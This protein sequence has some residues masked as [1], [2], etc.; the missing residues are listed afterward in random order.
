MSN[1]S[2]VDLQWGRDVYFQVRCNFSFSQQ[3]KKI[4]LKITFYDFQWDV[5][6]N[7]DF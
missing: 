3:F 1:R 6:G 4:L 2:Y 7:V 5:L